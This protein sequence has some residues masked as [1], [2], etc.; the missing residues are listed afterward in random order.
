VILALWLL[1]KGIAVRSSREA[2]APDA[3]PSGSLVR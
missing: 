2:P 1:I 3:T